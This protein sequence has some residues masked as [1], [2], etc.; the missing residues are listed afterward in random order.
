MRLA[1]LVIVVSLAA[2][3]SASEPPEPPEPTID[4]AEP[5]DDLSLY[6]DSDP[7]TVRLGGQ[8]M[9]DSA[10]GDLLRYATQAEGGAVSVEVRGGFLV[11]TP[12]AVGSALVVVTAR[13][14]E[15]GEASDTFAVEVM[16]PCP[17]T[18]TA[19][20]GLEFF[21]AAVG[22]VWTFDAEWGHDWDYSGGRDQTTGVMTWAFVEAECREGTF[23]YLVEEGFVGEFRR[24]YETDSNLIEVRDVSF[25]RPLEFVVSDSLDLGGYTAAGPV[26]VRLGSSS[27]DTT[28][29]TRFVNGTGALWRYGEVRVLVRGEGLIHFRSGQHYGPS[30]GHPYKELHR[31]DP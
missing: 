18:P 21:P 11:V 13:G 30:G 17:E 3:D 31:V 25:Q 22:D 23:H 12:E 16:D 26:A 29:T 1:A 20:Q 9:A 24:Y 2:C 4:V 8:F 27:T 10:A 28:N 6:L 7:D 5:F 19:D 15:G 14:M